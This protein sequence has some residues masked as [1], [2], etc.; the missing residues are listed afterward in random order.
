MERA[1]DGWRRGLVEMANKTAMPKSKPP[2][3]RAKNV[4]R[5]RFLLG[6]CPL[7]PAPVLWYVS[8][9]CYHG[10]GPAGRATTG[11]TSKNLGSAEIEAART[12][13]ASFP[14]EAVLPSHSAWGCHYPVRLSKAT[15][16]GGPTDAF[17]RSAETRK[18]RGSTK[19]FCNTI[20]EEPWP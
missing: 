7:A 17:A 12:R 10:R 11:Y 3:P 14:P 20:T 15:P 16:Y 13:K 19:S 18:L 5:T 9:R 4:A 1:R 8:A 6:V 2:H